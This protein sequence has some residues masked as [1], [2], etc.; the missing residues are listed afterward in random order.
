MFSLLYKKR[1]YSVNNNRAWSFRDLFVA[2]IYQFLLTEID[3]L[4]ARTQFIEIDRTVIDARAFPVL[5]FVL[6]KEFPETNSFPQ[7]R[8]GSTQSASHSSKPL[9]SFF[10]HSKLLTVEF[11][12]NYQQQQKAFTVISGAFDVKR[13]YSARESKHTLPP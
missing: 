10:E 4:R 3:D 6:K 11:N 2:T 12:Y 8:K 13:H 7:V 9:N 1:L 5:D